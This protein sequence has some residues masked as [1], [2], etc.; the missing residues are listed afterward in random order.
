MEINKRSPA[1]MFVLPYFHHH[2]RP[3]KTQTGFTSQQLA[4]ISHQ[5]L[6][7]CGGGLPCQRMF[8]ESMTW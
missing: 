4:L 8:Q 3:P 6:L 5:L 2:V 7:G 1:Q